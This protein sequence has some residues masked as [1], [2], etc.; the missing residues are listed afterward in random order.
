MWLA[1]A[2]IPQWL[3]NGIYGSPRRRAQNRADILRSHRRISSAWHQKWL[4]TRPFELGDE[5]LP[6]MWMW[7]GNQD[8][9]HHVRI[10]TESPREAE[11]PEVHIIKKSSWFG[12]KPKK[13]IE[14]KSGCWSGWHFGGKTLRFI[15]WCHIL[16]CC[17]P[18]L[19]NPSTLDLNCTAVFG[20]VQSQCLSHVFISSVCPTGIRVMNPPKR[21]SCNL[22]SNQ[23][24]SCGT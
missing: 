17:E 13:E 23:V 6:A 4:K 15:F 18:W 14:R 1:L 7:Q 12:E 11:K 3:P 22:R 2:H 8:F 16:K 10:L 20:A 24:A 19:S 21:W 9:D 5:Y